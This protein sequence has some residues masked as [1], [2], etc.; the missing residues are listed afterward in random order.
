MSNQ[1]IVRS[2]GSLFICSSDYENEY[3]LGKVVNSVDDLWNSQKMIDLS[4]MHKE[5]RWDEVGI[6]KFS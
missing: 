4:R 6:C 2:D 5:E 1:A 3:S